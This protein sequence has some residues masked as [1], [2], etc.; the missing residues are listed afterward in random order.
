MLEIVGCVASM[1]FRKIADC[2]EF[3]SLFVGHA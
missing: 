3:R 2:I 1:C